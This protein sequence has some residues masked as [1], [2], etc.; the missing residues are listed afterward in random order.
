M[1]SCQ[2]QPKHESVDSVP[3]V[4]ARK[5][6]TAQ[7]RGAW[8]RSVWLAIGL[9]VYLTATVLLFAFGP[10]RWV[11]R[12]P[13]MLYGFLA[14]SQTT[15]FIGCLMGCRPP[16]R[17]GHPTWNGVVILDASLVATLLIV[18]VQVVTRNFAGI[19]ILEAVID[20]AKAYYASL[21]VN[22]DYFV[23]S[24]LATVSAPLR[25]AFMPAAIMCWPLLGAVRRVGVAVAVACLLSLGLIS[26]QAFGVFDVI[27]YLPIVYTLSEPRSL[28]NNRGSD[29]GY[30]VSR[31]TGVAGYKVSQVLL[32]CAAAC[33]AVGYF[34]H[35]R[36]ARLG[37][38]IPREAMSWSTEIFGFRL[39]EVV[40][41]GLFYV[42]RYL[43]LG[44][45][46][47]AGCLELP[48]EWTY[49][50]GHSA[51][52]MRY[53]AL[54][55]S[56][57]SWVGQDTYPSRLES[58]SGYAVANYWHTAYPWLASDFSWAGAVV[59]I[60]AV[61]YLFCKTASEYCVTQ[62]IFTLSACCQCWFVLVYLPANCERFNRPEGFF[63]FYGSLILWRLSRNR[64]SS[65]RG[66]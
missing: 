15:L 49:G 40:E 9:Q 36:M 54:F 60:T 39:P 11:V 8:S 48:F 23:I 44:Y 1:V 64:L 57:W 47:L 13:V 7:V 32:Y 46:G 66:R 14:L 2:E 52:L 45:Y 29:S 37:E 20:P 38:N 24:V 21:D 42:S 61:G 18:P 53:A 5:S 65:A 63:A 33:V 50:L 17:R 58:I 51:F 62:D 26:G 30:P 19:S 3:W 34:V 6:L 35:S 59:L 16:M 25:C 22:R 31:R 10:C 56:Q 41:F 27:L 4:E 12:Y 43:T 55:D 28:T